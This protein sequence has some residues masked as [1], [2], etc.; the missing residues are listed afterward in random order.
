MWCLLPFWQM[1]RTNRALSARQQDGIDAGIIVAFYLPNPLEKLHHLTTKMVWCK[2]MFWSKF[3]IYTL[4]S[5]AWAQIRAVVKCICDKIFHWMLLSSWGKS[6]HDTRSLRN[7]A[8]KLLITR[9]I[10]ICTCLSCFTWLSKDCCTFLPGLEALGPRNYITIHDQF[11]ILSVWELCVT[12]DP[13]PPRSDSARPPHSLP[14]SSAVFWMLHGNAS[15]KWGNTL[16]KEAASQLAGGR[17]TSCDV[18]CTR[19]ILNH[20]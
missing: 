4:S 9:S 1:A 17:N 5:P 6:S 7:A 13:L 14:L 15:M 20:H 8:K 11:S 12:S 16:S 10:Q 19:Y 18:I 3:K 2:Q